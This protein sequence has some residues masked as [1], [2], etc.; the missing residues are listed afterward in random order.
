M[1]R[2]HF[3]QQ[4][5]DEQ[6]EKL[7]NPNLKKL[8]YLHTYGV[9]QLAGLLAIK[10]N[11]NIELAKICAL[12]HDISQY[13]ENASRNEHAKRSSIYA[14]KLLTSSS[15]FEKDEIQ[16]I[17]DAIRTHSDKATRNDSELGELLKDADLLQHYLFDPANVIEKNALFRLYYVLEELK[18]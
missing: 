13:T 9:F 5:V 4:H 17:C 1:N 2:L 12:L 10:R 18:N 15:L 7:H 8:A 6:I 16:K 14:Q 11:I 3:I